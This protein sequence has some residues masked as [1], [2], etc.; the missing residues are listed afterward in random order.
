MPATPKFIHRTAQGA[1][2][3]AN[4]LWNGR[5]KIPEWTFHSSTENPEDLK[6]LTGDPKDHAPKVNQKAVARAKK[7]YKTLGLDYERATSDPDYVEKA[8]KQ[9]MGKMK[10]AGVDIAD[11]ASISDIAA[12]YDKMSDAQKKAYSEY[13]GSAKPGSSSTTSNNDPNPKVSNGKNKLSGSTDPKTSPPL[14]PRPVPDSEVRT[15]QRNSGTTNS[16]TVVD[17]I[18]DGNQTEIKNNLEGAARAKTG[19]LL[20]NAKTAKKDAEAAGRVSDEERAIREREAK[21]T[22]HEDARARREKKHKDRMAAIMEDR[23]KNRSFR[24]AADWENL[25]RLREGDTVLSKEDL[26]KKVT[27]LLARAKE[28]RYGENRHVLSPNEFRDM[29]ALFKI[30]GKAEK[31]ADGNYSGNFTKAQLEA[32]DKRIKGFETTRDSRIES[33][34]AQTASLLASVNRENAAKYREQYGLHDFSDAEVLAFRE[35]RKKADAKKAL[36]ELLSMEKENEKKNEKAPVT[37]EDI[38]KFD[39]AWDK[40]RMNTNI[41]DAFNRAMAKK[42]DKEA[43]MDAVAGISSPYMREYFRKS[44]ILNQLRKENNLDGIDRNAEASPTDALRAV[45][46][47]TVNDSMEGVK[48]DAVK[49][50]M[51][52]V[53]TGSLED[54]E[55]NALRTLRTNALGTEDTGPSSAAESVITEEPNPGLKPRNDEK[56]ETQQAYKGGTVLRPRKKVV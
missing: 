16:D 55:T 44:T 19:A 26:N 38:T 47:D 34:K 18:S 12:A 4:F 31:G 52:G 13:G 5:W 9:V 14:T 35:R 43:Y 1:E 22:L 56:K 23:Y 15:T 46:T 54:A 45:K 2:L 48:T 24:D 11:D 29:T 32:L 42:E 17:G 8:F 6:W 51:E 30:V 25:G 7:A 39:A 40:L 21:D 3:L 20:S 37:K 50:S 28:L 36:D 33:S 27:D 49:D 10:A 41:T 53:E